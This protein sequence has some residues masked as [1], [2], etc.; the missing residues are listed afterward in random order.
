MC[1]C[2]GECCGGGCGGGGVCVCV[3]VCVCD[4]MSVSLI[5]CKRFGLLQDAAP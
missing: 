2:V 3:C 4:K 5:H 1:V